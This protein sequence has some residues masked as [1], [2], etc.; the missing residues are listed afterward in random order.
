MILDLSRLSNHKQLTQ[1]SCVPMSVETVLKL[2]NLMPKNDFSLQLDNSKSGN[3]N[4]LYPHFD[5]PTIN[6]R[7]QFKREYMLSDIG[8]PDRG[9]YFMQNF[10][11][12]L[13]KT[14]DEELL[15]NR[16]VIMSLEIRSSN[17]A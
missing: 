4:W 16:N 11:D 12:L 2:L 14:I 3:S 7:V 1:C 9:P 13:F 5:Y 10:F 6:P 17:V 8:Q 15:H